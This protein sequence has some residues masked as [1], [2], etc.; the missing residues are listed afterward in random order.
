MSI[1][2]T[3]EYTG[4]YIYPVA[5]ISYPEKFPFK[6][7]NN[8]IVLAVRWSVKYFFVPNSSMFQ[9][10][11]EEKEEDGENWQMQGSLLFKQMQ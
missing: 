11:C 1:L 8:W 7:T 2:T 5:L 10:N 3:C 4:A 6:L 9:K